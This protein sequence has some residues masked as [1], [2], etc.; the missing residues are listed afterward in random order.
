[1][2]LYITRHGRT[3][4]NE[5]Q[6]LQGWKDSDL[7]EEGIKRAEELGQSLKNIK[8]DAIYSSSQKRAIHTAEILSANRDLEII[9]LDDLKE[10]G[11]GSWEG[12]SREKLEENHSEL[13][14]IYLNQ[15]HLYVPMDGESYDSIFKRVARGLETI[16]RSG[17]ENV[18]LVSHGVTIKILMAILKEIPLEELST[19][20][21]FQGTSLTIV[22]FKDNDLKFLLE[23][24]TSHF[25]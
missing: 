19:I 25:I 23:G 20:P 16:L 12:L 3:I 22:E 18:L 13:F 4:W 5:E 9:Q 14:H 1:M 24:D 7:T 11:F 6:R 21:I 15:P 17:H 2:K 10:I 8:F